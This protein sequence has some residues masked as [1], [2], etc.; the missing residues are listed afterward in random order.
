MTCCPYLYAIFRWLAWHIQFERAASPKNDQTLTHSDVWMWVADE[1]QA[2]H[3]LVPNLSDCYQFVSLTTAWSC[4]SQSAMTMCELFG[5]TWWPPK[6]LSDQILH[7]I[8]CW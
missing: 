6:K 7:P 8:N 1:W 3:P 4:Q 2:L 5:V